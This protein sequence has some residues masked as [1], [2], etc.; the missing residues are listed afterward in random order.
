MVYN[1]R[2]VAVLF[3]FDIDHCSMGGKE[4]YY[5]TTRGGLGVS[6]TLNLLK[7]GRVIRHLMHDPQKAQG[8]SVKATG[9]RQIERPENLV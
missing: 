8:R 7:S 6:A 2:H 3:G 1:K 5:G 4:R 9:G